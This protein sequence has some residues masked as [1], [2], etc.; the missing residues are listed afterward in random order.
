MTS[1]VNESV[2][3]GAGAIAGARFPL[4]TDTIK[5][6]IPKMKA[7]KKKKSFKLKENTQTVDRV[8]TTSLKELLR[9]KQKAGEL[10]DNSEVFALED[11]DGAI[12]KVYVQP[13]Q[14]DNF[15][16][17]LELAL[18][19]A[20]DEGIEIAEVLFNLHRSFDIVHVEWGNGSIPEDEEVKPD[21]IENSED[22]E[23]RGFPDS[24]ELGDVDAERRGTPEETSD[25]EDGTVD[26]DDLSDIADPTV[27]TA[28]GEG[29]VDQVK[30]MNQIVSLLQSQ[31]D[32]QRAKAEAEKAQADV[33]AAE[34]AAKAAAHYAS[35]QEEVMDME[36]YNKHQQEQKRQSQIQAKL[37]R[38]RHDLRKDQDSDI[39][40]K[41][42]DPQFLL[43]TLHK[44]NIGES[45]MNSSSTLPVN[46]PTPEEE[47]I[48]RM[49]D[50]E[51]AQKE[52][53]HKQKLRDRLVRYKYNQ[54]K[55]DGE[56]DQGKSEQQAAPNQEGKKR[57]SLMD[58][59]LA[60]RRNAAQE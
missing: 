51:K 4:F 10:N 30:L 18:H 55:A 16:S 39:S 19:N 37:L 9:A 48:L 54:R 8:T 45:T 50:W 49:E 32:A 47:E 31:A 2:S 12:V 42:N 22:A 28:S 11:N 27:Q 34:A 17:A 53:Q 14:A 26:I 25:V 46:D 40:D 24:D 36:N 20:E 23:E 43:N 33:A 7:P 15:R 21:S 13:D 44:A 38:Y 41:L 58:Y 59:L 1:T 52:T 3:I 60:A 5:R 29:A 6:S 56:Q 35:H 57:G